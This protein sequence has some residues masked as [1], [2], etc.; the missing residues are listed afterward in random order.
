MIILKASQ[1]FFTYAEVTNL[2]R[3]SHSGRNDPRRFRAR[4]C[5]SGGESAKRLAALVGPRED[6]NPSLPQGPVP[7]ACCSHIAASWLATR[8]H[9]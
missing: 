9:Q 2:L 8:L 3:M 1:K 5:Q 6:Q 4:R 7:S